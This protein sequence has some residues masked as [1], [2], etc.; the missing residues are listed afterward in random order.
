MPGV[1]VTVPAGAQP[2]RA[3]ARG[4]R[5]LRSPSRDRTAIASVLLRRSRVWQGD[6]R[7]A[8][9]RSHRPVRSA[10]PGRA[11]AAG[12]RRAGPRRPGGERLTTHMA[13][14][15]R[16]PGGHVVH[17]VGEVEI[18]VLV[19]FVLGAGEQQ[20]AVDQPLVPGVDLQQG[21]AGSNVSASSL[22]SSGRR[23][24][25]MRSCRLRS[26]AGASTIRCAVAVMWSVY[27]CVPVHRRRYSCLSSVNTRRLRLDGRSRFGDGG[28][29]QTSEG[30][31]R[32]RSEGPPA[33]SAEPYTAR[34]TWWLDSGELCREER[35]HRRRRHG[36]SRPLVEEAA[37]VRA[38]PHAVLGRDHRCATGRSRGP[39]PD[40]RHP[41][42]EHLGAA[43]NMTIPTER[44]RLCRAGKA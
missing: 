38:G 23:S 42:P 14:A 39:R 26:A 20:E 2:V 22:I 3:D 35:G 28:R 27:G 5:G 11:A 21:A 4:H 43:G 12:A 34:S 18:G 33:R 37:R 44:E 6:V 32:R 16:E 40:C 10:H 29:G 1:R 30:G 7:R 31:S 24:S 9:R 36:R 19:D 13:G 8:G 15:G 17:D 25:A 41:A